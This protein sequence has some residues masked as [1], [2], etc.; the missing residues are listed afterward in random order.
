MVFNHKTMQIGKHNTIIWNILETPLVMGKESDAPRSPTAKELSLLFSKK[1]VW[2]K[3]D[4]G[5]N[6]LTSYI[7][8]QGPVT[9][10]QVLDAMKSYYHSKLSVSEKKVYMQSGV[11]AYGWRV[12]PVSWM[13][14]NNMR[15][16]M[17]GDSLY[18]EGFTFYRLA[19]S[20]V[21]CS[22]YFGS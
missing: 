14:N 1:S 13:K 12:D 22:P 19:D 3:L 4:V 16:Q 7:F 5:F 21:E 15:G 9:L 20:S 8:L 2:L 11:F 10:D 6:M 17:R 18:L